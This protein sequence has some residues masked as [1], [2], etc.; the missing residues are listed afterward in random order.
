MIEV[1]IGPDSWGV[2]FGHD[3]HQPT[4]TQFLDEVVEA[5]YLWIERGPDGYLP[6]DIP[7]L[8]AELDARGLRLS[9]VHAMRPLE[10]PEAWVSLEADIE[11]A[12]EVAAAFGARTLVLIDAMYTDPFTGAHTAP[13]ELDESGWARLV[14]TTNRVADLTRER[15]NMSVG[16]HPHVDTHVAREDQIERLLAETEPERVSLC[17]D[18]GHHAYL[19]ADAV[20]FLRRHASRVS[21]LHLKNV[22]P[23][24]RDHVAKE[25][26]SFAAAVEADV[27]TELPDGAVDMKALAALLENIGYRGFAVVEQDMYPAPFDKPLPIARRTRDYLRELGIG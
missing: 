23:G 1:G 19:G 5:G 6:V 21:Y 12:C 18:I 27:F 25:G 22:D 17:F 16:F 7:R 24:V 4:W 15:W 11:R 2:W 9:A 26:L 10:D 20:A 3:P 8:R 14:E 13:S